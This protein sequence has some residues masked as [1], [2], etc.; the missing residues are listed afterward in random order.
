MTGAK[1]SAVSLHGAGVELPKLELVQPGP[2]PT[3]SLTKGKKGTKP[4]KSTVGL[5]A[6]C[7]STKSKEKSKQQETVGEPITATI[8]QKT[9]TQE[10]KTQEIH[11]A[12][13]VEAPLSLSTTTTGNEPILPKVNIDI[14]RERSFQTDF[15]V[16]L[17]HLFE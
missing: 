8:D 15:K 14:F 7:F 1:K 3:L 4:K 13:I 16:S 10:I 12:P 2:L 6:S 11:T 5:C 17:K 9:T